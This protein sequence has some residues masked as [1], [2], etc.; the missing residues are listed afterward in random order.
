MSDETGLRSPHLSEEEQQ[1]ASS[2]AVVRSLV[3]H[4]VV[5]EQGKQ[6]L[7][8]SVGSLAWSG[9]GAGLSIGFSMVMQATLQAGLP[10]APWSRLVDS[11]GYSLGFLIVV[12]GQQQLFTETTLTALIPTLTN[13]SL[14]SLVGTMRVW[15]VVLV[16]NLLGTWIFGAIVAWPGLFPPDTFAAMQSLGAETMAHPFG[17]TVVTATAAGWLIGLMIWLLPGGGPSR[18]LIIVLLTYAV[19]LCHFPHVIAGSTE[20]AFAVVSGHASLSG[21]L[22][23]FLLPTLLGNVIGGT[24]MVALLN[25]AQIADELKRPD[26]NTA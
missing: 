12:L 22:L 3:I 25:H 24:A 1:Q 11:F 17:H 20:A 15:A 13:R 21:Y 23:R 18:P 4:E 9:L 7:E 19:S 14:S 6:E 26:R 16:A 5:R 10:A 8:R 2:N